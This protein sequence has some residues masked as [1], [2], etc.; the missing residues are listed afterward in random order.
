MQ[1]K[2]PFTIIIADDDFDEIELLKI[3]FDKHP[4]FEIID[5]VYNGQEIIDTV[6]KGN[7]LPDV[8]L[9]DMYMPILN[10]LETTE[11]LRMKEENADISII[12]F[13]TSMN[14]SITEK[15][16]YLNITG[17]LIKPFILD[18]YESLPDK[19]AAILY[20]KIPGNT[21]IPL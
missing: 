8:I 3:A 1:Q 21:S 2:K 11:I 9:T 7:Q 18:D 14:P 20:G 10:G 5:C 6:A 12:I 15:A 16:S 17:T 19:V 13:S 4:N